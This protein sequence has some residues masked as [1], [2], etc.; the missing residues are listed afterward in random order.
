MPRGSLL[1]DPERVFLSDFVSIL[2]GTPASSFSSTTIQM[3]RKCG[4][5]IPIP[6]FGFAFKPCAFVVPETEGRREDAGEER[7]KE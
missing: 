5:M 3:W 2:E 1:A 6:L 4:D 7:C